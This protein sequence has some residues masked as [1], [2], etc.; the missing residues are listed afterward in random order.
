MNNCRNLRGFQAAVATLCVVC[1]PSNGVAEERS[2]ELDEANIYYQ[3]HG[4]GEPLLLVH[5]FTSTHELWSDLTP[6]LAN[7]Y[8]LIVPDMRGHGRSQNRSGQFLHAD[9]AEDM[10]SLLDHVGVT[11]VRA[12]GHSSGALTLLH[13]AIKDPSRFNSLVLM[14]TPANPTE[15]VNEF[16][17]GIT[18]GGYPDV[19]RENLLRWH[20]GGETQIGKLLSHLHQLAAEDETDRFF[21]REQLDE[22][23]AR[24]L[25]IHGDRD[26]HPVEIATDI[27]RSIPN[28]YLW[29]VPNGDHA[30]VFEPW[31][32][33]F[34]GKEA[35]LP[36][37]MRFLAPH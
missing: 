16:L 35:F 2:L 25:I 3:I 26:I 15:A 4:D 14:G 7:S 27:Y 28:A 30:L 22:I 34:E 6:A 29:V 31:G 12:I 18:Y 13:A 24:T 19:I 1:S 10:L 21:S 20:P 11:S 23:T 9:S 5:G 32:G 8:R 17:L 36:V 33:T 37:L